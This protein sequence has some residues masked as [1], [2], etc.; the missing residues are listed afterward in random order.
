MPKLVAALRAHDENIK[1]AVHASTQAVE[2]N[3]CRR[4]ISTESGALPL[5]MMTYDN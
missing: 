2:V 1:P 4:S 3:A 5:F